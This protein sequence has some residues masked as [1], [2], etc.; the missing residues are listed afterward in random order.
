MEEKPHRCLDVKCSVILH[1]S[2]VSEKEQHGWTE[3][4][5]MYD[6]CGNLRPVSTRAVSFM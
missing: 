6:D 5:E 4:E 3:V 1:L 2:V